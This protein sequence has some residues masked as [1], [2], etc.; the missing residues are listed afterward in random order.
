MTEERDSKRNRRASD[1]P[2]DLSK[3]REAF[4]RQF[5]RKGVELTEEL[6]AENGLLRKQI[7][8]LEDDNARLRAHVASD[9]AIRDLIARIDAL[10]DE[11]NRL[12]DRSTALERSQQ[13]DEGRY[14]QIES[15][16]NDLANLYIA[17]Y[18]LHASLSLRRVVRHL[19]DTIGQLI[20][21]NA[22]VIYLLDPPGNR[23]VPL[24]WEQLEEGDV[25][26]IPLGEGPVGEACLTGIERIR[27][28]LRHGSLEDPIAVIP[29]MV[30]E[31]PIG[32]VAVASMLE[33]KK[34]WASVDGE[35]FKLLGAH[36]GTA[37]I[38][39]NLFA[40]LSR[41]E[42]ALEG[43]FDNLLRRPSAGPPPTPPDGD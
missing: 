27:Q 40:G 6:L 3:E 8:R 17:S 34:G 14:A 15:E 35:L 33:Q 19:K 38:A 31:R 9:D 13:E 21:A 37:L 5:L 28:D 12:L 4:V 23:V 32:A 10:E 1:V 7:A 22:F 41:P 29:L 26:P 25:H 39:A 24:G 36:G 2:V 30:G 11:K 18:Q 20:G 16:L 42:D 43:L